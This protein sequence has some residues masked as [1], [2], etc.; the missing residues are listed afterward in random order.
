MADGTRAG[1]GVKVGGFRSPRAEAVCDL[2]GYVA[3]IALQ[4]I[5]ADTAWEAAEHDL[6][7]LIDTGIPVGAWPAHMDSARAILSK[8][9]R[10]W[11]RLYQ[12]LLTTDEMSWR[13]A[14]T[15]LGRR[16]PYRAGYRVQ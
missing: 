15:I 14:A 6:Q 5:P 4:D 16:D 1:G 12:R 9:R 10:Q 8:R 7:N 3:N 13:D 2:S 11:E